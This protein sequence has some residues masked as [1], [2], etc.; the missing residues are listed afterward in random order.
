[1]GTEAGLAFIQRNG[2]DFVFVSHP[3]YLRQ[4]LYSDTSGVY[5][6]NQFRFMMLCLAA[7]EAP[8]L[9]QL[10]GSTYGE[11]CVFVANDWHAAL[12]PVLLAAKYRPHNVYRNARTILAIH[13]LRHQ[14]VF[15]PGTFPELGLP[16]EWYGA[17]EFQYPP[18]LRQGAYEEEGR[19]I[20]TLK[21]GIATCDR[22][23]T[24]S[25]GY[26]FEIQTVEGGWDLHPLLSSRGYVLNGILNGIDM[27]VWNPEKDTFIE[28][29]YSIGDFSQGKAANKRAL[30]RE[31]G[32]PERDVLMIGFIGRLD[33]QKGA[34]L[35]LGVA[36]WLLAQD[37]Q[38]VCLGTGD[39]SLENGMR[40]LENTYSDRA[41]AWVGFNETMSHRITAAVDILLMP[42]RFEPCG[43]NQLYAMRYGS[44]PVAHATGGLKDTVLNFDPFQNVGTGWTFS[45]CTVESFRWALET[46]MTTYWKYPDAFRGLQTTGMKRNSSWGEAAKEYEQIFGWALADP[47]YCS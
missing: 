35:V 27:E 38:L 31:L 43:L 21:G 4:G 10:N 3:S 14:G 22:L 33:Y 32:L 41:R 45:P 29:N 39:P 30:Q 2:V 24:V 20:N 37:V 36:P 44:V 8:L 18:H 23:V 34:D 17:M 47:P 26:A 11:D 13:N 15:A 1:M 5:G 12:T 16:G 42:S 40:W 6:D 46:A 9:L 7:L 19:C 25:P 28:H